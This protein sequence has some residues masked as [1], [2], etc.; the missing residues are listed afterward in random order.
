MNFR[1]ASLRLAAGIALVTTLCAQR[2]FRVYRSME[3][4]D[5]V[6]LPPDYQE[7]TEWVFARLMFPQHPNAHFGHYRYGSSI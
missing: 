7:K 2:P 4:Y 6:Q 3:P 5:N 1:N